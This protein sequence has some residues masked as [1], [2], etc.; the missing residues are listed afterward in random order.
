MRR[1]RVC[2]EI[3]EDKYR[4]YEH[5]AKRRGVT[6]EDLVEQVVK[7]LWQELEQ[8]E[9]EGTDHLIIPS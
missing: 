4:A 7:G 3:P 6:V 8:E 5:E 2:V 1:V 9:T